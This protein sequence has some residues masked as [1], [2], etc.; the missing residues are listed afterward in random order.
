MAD[1][2]TGTGK[3][4]GEPRRSCARKQRSSQSFIESFQKQTGSSLKGLNLGQHMGIKIKDEVKFTKE[5][6]QDP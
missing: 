4:Q 3:F 2:R 5:K 6:F 1:C